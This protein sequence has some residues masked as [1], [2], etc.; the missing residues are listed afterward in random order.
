MTPAS[1][2]GADNA[3][4]L[5]MN[6]LKPGRSPSRVLRGVR[7]RLSRFLVPVELLVGGLIQL[8]RCSDIWRDSGDPAAEFG[9]AAIPQRADKLL[10]GAA[11]VVRK[12]SAKLVAPVRYAVASSG[13]SSLRAA[14]NPRR[15]SSPAGCPS[16]SLICLKLSRS[17]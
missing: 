10:C 16:V 14:A 13:N 9:H 15:M 3:I 12:Q 1:A 6:G 5:D 7:L 8:F 4:R 11:H 17:K 2:G